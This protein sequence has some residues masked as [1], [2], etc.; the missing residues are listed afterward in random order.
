MTGVEYVL[1]FVLLSGAA[2][3]FGDRGDYE[4]DAL[5]ELSCCRLY[6]DNDMTCAHRYYWQPLAYHINLAVLSISDSP[7]LMRYLA[8]M[9]GAA[10]CGMLTAAVRGWSGRRHSIVFTA[11]LLLL[12]PELVF[13]LLYYN[14][15]AFGMGFL[16]LACLLATGA[17]RCGLRS[18]AAAV[19]CG[20][21]VMSRFEFILI[22]PLFMYFF[23]PIRGDRRSLPGFTGVSGL[24]FIVMHGL[25]WLN[26]RELA[27]VHYHHREL[28]ALYEQSFGLS[29]VHYLKVLYVIMHPVALGAI[30]AYAVFFAVRAV[31]RGELLKLSIF[32]IVGLALYPV[33]FL[34]SG[35]YLVPLLCF[36]PFL[37]V[38]MLDEV[39]DL[40]SAPV[41]T[42]VKAGAVCFI[43]AVQFTSLDPLLMIHERTLFI[44]RE[45]GVHTHDGFRSSGAYLASFALVRRGRS[46]P[47]NEASLAVHMVDRICDIQRHTVILLDFER[48]EP[49]CRVNPMTLQLR[50]YLPWLLEMRGYNLLECAGGLRL[51]RDGHR[52]EI[53]GVDGSV[54]T[55]AIASDGDLLLVDVPSLTAGRDKA[56]AIRCVQAALSGQ[57]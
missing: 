22:V 6:Y 45:T 26:F 44:S 3:F 47:D 30:L 17:G 1:L 56:M 37:L 55:A 10:G 21:A 50:Q 29:H 13:C 33:C 53:L 12:L 5:L 34:T 36:V 9:A 39:A 7:W 54:D 49:G 14:S 8:A 38:R 40:V 2:V 41:F 52:V 51:E 16:G 46:E 11:A 4:Y 35:K 57:E 28:T 27:A 15:T 42:T 31:R 19:A 23:M 20:C 18:A 43:A 25:G 24:F 48:V 32:P